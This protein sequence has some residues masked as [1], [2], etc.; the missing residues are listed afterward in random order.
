MSER[1]MKVGEFALN[2]P[3]LW[4]R[5]IPL[6]YIDVLR[7]ALTQTV[8]SAMLAEYDPEQWCLFF[9][10]SIGIEPVRIVEVAALEE[11]L[12]N[13]FRIH[14]NHIVPTVEYTKKIWS[15]K[16]DMIPLLTDPVFQRLCV[17]MHSHGLRLAHD[18][19]GSLERALERSRARA[20]EVQE[21]YQSH[22]PEPYQQQD[23]LEDALGK[24]KISVG[25]LENRFAEAHLLMA[26][27][28]VTELTCAKNDTTASRETAAQHLRNAELLNGML[29]KWYVVRKV[30]KEGNK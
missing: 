27:Q 29:S 7:A 24:P 8:R 15:L 3:A 16:K 26:R 4:D 13:R 11:F 1:R 9:E 14:F 20:T 10:D 22:F 21:V 30:E 12:C 2:Q 6:R 23:D 25:E 28:L 18:E 19:P 5:R 17:Y